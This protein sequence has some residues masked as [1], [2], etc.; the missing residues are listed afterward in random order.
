[1]EGDENLAGGPLE[2][3]AIVEEPG[4]LPRAHTLT[5]PEGDH[6]VPG[7]IRFLEPRHAFVAAPDNHPGQN[8]SLRARAAGLRGNR[9]ACRTEQYR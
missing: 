5:D 7:Q 3:D 8:E 6:L 2:L 4:Q 9:S 1:V